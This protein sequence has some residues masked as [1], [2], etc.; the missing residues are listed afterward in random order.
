MR[1]DRLVVADDERLER[2]GQHL[3]D[4]DIEDVVLLRR[5]QPASSQPAAWSR[6]LSLRGSRRAAH[7]HYRSP[8]RRLLRRVRRGGAVRQ[9]DVAG[10]LAARERR[11]EELGRSECGRAGLHVDI[12]GEGAVDDRRARPDGLGE[13]DAR[14]RLGVLEREARRG[15]RAPSRPPGERRDDRSRRRGRSRSAHAHRDVERPRRLR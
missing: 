7:H 12:R 14:E 10:E 1:R 13:G 4:L 2:I 3:Q 8:A 9:A 5:G 15:S 11:L 6:M